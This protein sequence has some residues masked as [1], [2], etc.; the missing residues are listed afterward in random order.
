MTNLPCSVSAGGAIDWH[1]RP[2]ST[3]F[4]SRPNA[5]PV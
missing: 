2:F 3:I 4:Q 1:T 5:D